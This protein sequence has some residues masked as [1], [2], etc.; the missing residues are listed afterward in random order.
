MCSPQLYVL[1]NHLNQKNI[2]SALQIPFEI[3]KIYNLTED[4]NYFQNEI[5]FPF[6]FL[7]SMPLTHLFLVSRT[8]EGWLSTSKSNKSV[9]HMKKGDVFSNS[10]QCALDSINHTLPYEQ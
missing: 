9:I 8:I 7:H 5:K 6:D 1:T 10:V 3:T 4:D 2:E